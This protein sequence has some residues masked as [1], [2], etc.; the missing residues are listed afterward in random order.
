MRVILCFVACFTL[1]SLRAQEVSIIPQPKSLVVKNG[2]FMLN[3]STPIVAISKDDKNIAALFNT[4]LKSCYG[5]TLPVVSKGT[6]GILLTTKSASGDGYTLEADETAIRIAGNSAAGTFYGTQSLIQL[7]PVEKSNTLSVPTVSITDAP[8]VAYR[9]LMLDVGRHYFPVAFVKK[10]IDYIALHKMNYFHW[11]LTEDQG[12]RIEIKKYPKLTR[13]GAWRNGTIIGNYPGKG[14][15]N[16]RYGGFYTQAEVKE[17]VAYAAKRYITVIPEIEMPGHGGGA[18]AAYPFLSCFPDKP[19]FDYFPKQS[20]WSGDKSGK[21]VQQAW[22]VYEDVFCAGKESTFKFLED[23][24]NEVLPLFPS[25]YVH[26]G[27]DE[28][29]KKNWEKCPNCQKRIRELGIKGDKEHSPEHYLQS[30]FIQRMEKFINAKGRQIIGWDEILEGGLAPNAT[31][32]SWRGEKGGITAARQKHQV[33]MTP[34]SYVYFDYQQSPK[35]D[36]V[37]ITNNRNYL[38]IEKVYNWKVVP[39][40]LT[41]DERP[42]IWGGQANLWTEYVGNP[43][44][45]E[46][47]LFPRMSALSEA[48]WKPKADRNFE[49]FKKRLEVQKKRYDLWGAT[50]FGK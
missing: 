6:K 50:Y 4:Y 40:S 47:M 43:Q 41:A 44:K 36:S 42:L 14:N 32:M 18:I 46:Y 16:K 10:Y 27:G 21:Q 22:G 34:N 24:L 17:I 5:F 20:T 9:G 33:I 23:V 11:H 12:W 30:Y 3:R 28:C 1:F 15:D 38:P 26:I 31:V 37:T 7:L 8:D 45:A 48:L 19:T 39:D 49:D 29:P 13:V 35:E 25:K 2:R